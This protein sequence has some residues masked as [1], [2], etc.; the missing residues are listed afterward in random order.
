M[1]E[2][3]D[4]S[5]P[6]PQSRIFDSVAEVRHARIGLR[7]FALYVALY[8]GFVGLSAF[9]PRV[10]RRAALGSLNVAIVYGFGLILAAFMLAVLYMALC[11]SPEPRD[12]PSDPGAPR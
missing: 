1:A 6:P 3:P 8:A 9:A 5:T 10:M 11:R 12:A 4:E 2:H 7:L